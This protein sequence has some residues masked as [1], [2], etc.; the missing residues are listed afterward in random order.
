MHFTLT[1][2]C[3]DKPGIVAAVSTALADKGADILETHQ[4]SD[5]T[6][7]RL[8]MRLAFTTPASMED[9]RACLEPVR[10]EFNMT[11]RL[12]DAA[13]LPR[14]I[15]MVSKFDHAL[16]NLLYQVRV[17]WLRAEIVTI[18]SNHQDSAATAAQAGIPYYY[19]PVNKDNKAEQEDRL[20][21]LVSE[22]KAD[23]IV[24]ARY[25]Q[26]LSDAFS[27]EMS[28]RIINIHHSFLPSFKGARPYHQAF[29]RGVK[30]IGATAHY[31][32]PDLDEGPIIEQ[33]TARVTHSL[34]AED[35]VAAGRSI[36]SQVLA[37]AVK[38]HVEQRVMLNG[39]RTIIFS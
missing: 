3:P 29:A 36:E 7:H 20:R 13:V 34:S 15:I 28:G 2:S 14:L 18:V 31:V 23:L 32:T 4:F 39:H 24:L 16:L 6:A 8:F 38:L 11:M 30:L 35:Y 25:M 22:T 21:A 27:T 17:N 5:R 26:V 1:F 12:H 19:W 37:R 10:T 9:I 33:E